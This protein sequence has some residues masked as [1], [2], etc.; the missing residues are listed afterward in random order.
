M[1]PNNTPKPKNSRS[2][3]FPSHHLPAHSS[4]ASP[5]QSHLQAITQIQIKETFIPWL[6]AHHS[7]HCASV[8]G[9]LVSQPTLQAFTSSPTEGLWLYHT[10][11]CTANASP[12]SQPTQHPRTLPIAKKSNALILA[13]VTTKGQCQNG[14]SPRQCPHKETF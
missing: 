7:H 6:P 13:P 14:S 8:P 12:S 11:S 2:P 9:R 3:T 4:K 1:N 5:S 10:C